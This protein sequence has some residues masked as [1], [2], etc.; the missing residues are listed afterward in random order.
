MLCCASSPGPAPDM[1][2]PRPIHCPAGSWGPELH[3]AGRGNHG[4]TQC[5]CSGPKL[6][7]EDAAISWWALEEEQT[8]MVAAV[9]STGP[10]AQRQ[11]V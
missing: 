2:V 1:F 8:S 6:P 3:Q 5:V 11:H 10:Q 7:Q 4:G 9:F